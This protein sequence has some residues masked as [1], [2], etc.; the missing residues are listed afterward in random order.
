MGLIEMASRNSLSR[1]Y[2]YYQL[3]KVLSW[4]DRDNGVYDGKVSGSDDNVYSVHIDTAHPKKSVCDCPFAAGRH[5]ACKHM[6]ALYF[7]ADPKAVDIYLNK[8]REWEEAA[9]E[10]ERQHKEEI[11]GYVNSL[12]KAELRERLY[13]ALLELEER[14]NYYW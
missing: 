11:R 13:E 1:G 4:E 6:L 9:E 14:E 3:N 8:V 2:E 5:V 12:T 7:T 10:M